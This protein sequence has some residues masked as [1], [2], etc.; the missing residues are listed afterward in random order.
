MEAKRAKAQKLCGGVFT[1]YLFKIH[2][3][4]EQFIK[5]EMPAKAFLQ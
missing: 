5:L 1:A 2:I 4:K 3:I